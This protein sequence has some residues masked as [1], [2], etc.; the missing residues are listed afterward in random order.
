MVFAFTPL[1]MFQSRKYKEYK[2]YF[3]NNSIGVKNVTDS[4][5]WLIERNFD[6]SLD[7]KLKILYEMLIGEKNNELVWIKENLINSNDVKNLCSINFRLNKT[8]E[9]WLSLNYPEH[10]QLIKIGYPYDKTEQ[11]KLYLNTIFE[12]DKKYEKVIDILSK[13]MTY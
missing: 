10:E 5:K 12:G 13:R 8:V 9:N 2:E 11:I 1:D 4:L 6:F 3:C 7:F